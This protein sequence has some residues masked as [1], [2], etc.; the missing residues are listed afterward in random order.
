MSDERVRAAS[1]LLDT[2]SRD[3]N[4]LERLRRTGWASDERERERLL[5]RTTTVR[6]EKK[7]YARRCRWWKPWSIRPTQRRIDWIAANGCDATKKNTFLSSL[8]FLERVR[9]SELGFRGGKVAVT[10]RRIQKETRLFIFKIQLNTKLA[11]YNFIHS[12][13]LDPHWT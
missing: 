1:C 3:E 8:H 2:R 11:D 6:R 12:V 9:G 5:F 10:N 7:H 4:W 13:T